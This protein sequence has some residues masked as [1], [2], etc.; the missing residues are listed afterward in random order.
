[1]LYALAEARFTRIVWPRTDQL[2]LA[3]LHRAAAAQARRLAQRHVVT[4]PSS[5]AAAPAPG[6][7]AEVTIEL[8]VDVQGSEAGVD[9]ELLAA[10]HLVHGGAHVVVDAA[11]GDATQRLE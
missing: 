6:N 9:D 7:V 11:P 3:A 10:L 4:G 2:Q 8:V 5:T 1:M